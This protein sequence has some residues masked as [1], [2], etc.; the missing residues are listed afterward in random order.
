MKEGDRTLAETLG[1]HTY[2]YTY[3]HTQIVRAANIQPW[4]R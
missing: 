1:H 2:T 4:K 3:I